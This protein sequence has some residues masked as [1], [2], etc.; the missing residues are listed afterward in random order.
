MKCPKCGEETIEMRMDG[1]PA[2]SCGKKTYPPEV[3][4]LVRAIRELHPES[5]AEGPICLHECAE[6][7][8]IDIGGCED[9]LKRAMKPFKGL[10]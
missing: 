8:A 2:H 6:C 7:S 4:T 1:T 3:L 9:R 5:E 10:K